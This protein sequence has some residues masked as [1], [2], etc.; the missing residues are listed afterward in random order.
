MYHTY[1]PLLRRGLLFYTFY[2]TQITR[3]W[4]VNGVSVG[5][6]LNP[7]SDNRPSQLNSSIT[8]TDTSHAQ[9]VKATGSTKE[10]TPHD[11]QNDLLGFNHPFQDMP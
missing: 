5:V 2:I 3:G 6:H 7:H 10:K 9:A 8:V 4:T 11:R 1:G